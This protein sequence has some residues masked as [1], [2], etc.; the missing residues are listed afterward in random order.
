MNFRTL[1][2]AVA[3]LVCMLLGSCAK[4]VIDLNGSIK[5]VVKDADD[6]HLIENCLVALSPGG[7]SKTT[8]QSGVF[9]FAALTPGEYTLLFTKTGYPNTTKTVTVVTGEE[10]NS[11]VLLKANSPFAFLIL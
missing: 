4:D 2:L 9:E 1:F 7:V 10:T 11:D 5:G 8:D 3:T 6:G